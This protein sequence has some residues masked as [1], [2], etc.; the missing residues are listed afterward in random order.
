MKRILN[1]LLN[2]A[3]VF[4][5]TETS[6]VAQSPAS[7]NNSRPNTNQYFH[8]QLGKVRVKSLSPSHGHK[9]NDHET[10]YLKFR[11]PEYPNGDP[12]EVRDQLP[13]GTKIQF[14]NGIIEL[15]GCIQRFHEA[16]DQL[17]VVNV[18]DICVAQPIQDNAIDAPMGS[19]A[20]F[21]IRMNEF[22]NTTIETEKVIRELEKAIGEFER[23]IQ[24]PNLSDKQKLLAA[25]YIR[26]QVIDQE[27]KAKL[28]S[29]YMKNS[30]K[31]GAFAHLFSTTDKTNIFGTYESKLER[32]KCYS[33]VIQ[34]NVKNSNTDQAHEIEVLCL[35]YI[36]PELTK[37]TAR[38][39]ISK[40]NINTEVTRR[41]AYSKSDQA[42]WESLL[43]SLQKYQAE[44]DLTVS[45]FTVESLEK[46]GVL[47]LSYDEIQR[48][49]LEI[50]KI[51]NSL[52]S[53]RVEDPNN[54]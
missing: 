20:E 4:Y 9:A 27:Q 33:S 43:P 32:N 30:A 21:K 50:A 40:G 8:V 49:S 44:N 26:S 25:K 12:I 41:F 28:K 37:R 15:E 5:C 13:W 24:N 14:K 54:K 1:L 17:R 51:N 52:D 16:K 10:S 19:S 35:E 53:L 6:S 45:G 22:S 38:L 42:D 36:T 7:D 3:I 29:S 31:I 39:L 11:F 2:L 23:T 48:L 46:L 47:T 34:T 18:E